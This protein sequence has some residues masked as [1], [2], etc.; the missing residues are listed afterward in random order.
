MVEDL[1]R[2]RVRVRN[3]H[4][5]LKAVERLKELRQEV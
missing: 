2:V 3:L 1:G 4:W 5:I